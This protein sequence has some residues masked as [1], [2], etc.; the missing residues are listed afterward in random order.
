MQNFNFPGYSWS[1]GIGAPEEETW[2]N[3]GTGKGREDKWSVNVDIVPDHSSIATLL[4]YRE[5]VQAWLLEFA[6]VCR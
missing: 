5:K 2:A 3:K 1:I 6:F 4:D